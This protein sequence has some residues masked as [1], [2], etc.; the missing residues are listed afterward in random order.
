[1]FWRMQLET[2]R[3]IG[4]VPEVEFDDGA[5]VHGRAGNLQQDEGAVERIESTASST[6]APEAARAALRRRQFVDGPKVRR[7]DRQDDELGNAV[8]LSNH[9]LVR[10]IEVHE[11]D[12]SPRRDSPRR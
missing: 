4:D 1:M 2:L 8:T 10:R 3:G 12:R 5:D 7:R 9:V 11:R 6:A